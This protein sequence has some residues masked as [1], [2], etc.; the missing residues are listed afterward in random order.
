[1]QLL[2]KLKNPYL[3]VFLTSK[4]ILKLIF[5]FLNKINKNK[6]EMFNH[7]TFALKM[8]YNVFT[9]YSK[10]TKTAYWEWG[11]HCNNQKS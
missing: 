10:I 5:L 6:T 8:S 4:R 9:L 7:N 3:K 1:M 11:L 2:N